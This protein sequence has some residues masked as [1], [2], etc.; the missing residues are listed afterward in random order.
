MLNCNVKFEVFWITWR[1]C[2]KYR[3]IV[4]SFIPNRNTCIDGH[5]S[6]NKNSIYGL[7]L[8]RAHELHRLLEIQWLNF[9]QLQ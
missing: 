9:S 5:I 2:Y 4:G 6:I 8:A 3:G 1:L 7:I